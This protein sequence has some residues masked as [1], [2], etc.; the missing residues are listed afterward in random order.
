MIIM[1]L[2]NELKKIVLQCVRELGVA[3]SKQIATKLR[4]LGVSHKN[5]AMTLLNCFRQRLLEREEFKR[6]RV[7]G[8][9]Y[10]LTERGEKRL[11]YYT[12][13]KGKARIGVVDFGELV[14]QA[15]NRVAPLWVSDHLVF[16]CAEDICNTAEQSS[17]FSMGKQCAALSGYS[18]MNKR[19]LISAFAAERLLSLVSPE[20]LA[21]IENALGDDSLEGLTDLMDMYSIRSRFFNLPSEPRSLFDIDFVMTY[22]LLRRM[23]ELHAGQIF[24]Y[25]KLQEEKQKRQEE[26]AEKQMYKQLYED[27]KA[28]RVKEE[29]AR[30]TQGSLLNGLD[31]SFGINRNK[32]RSLAIFYASWVTRLLKIVNT[33]NQVVETF[34]QMQ[35][36]ILNLLKRNRDARNSDT[37][38]IIYYL[39]KYIEKCDELVADN[40]RLHQ[41]AERL[42]ERVHDLQ[43][44]VLSDP[45]IPL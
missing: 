40:G 22:L 4:S 12:M 32:Y 10:I 2:K 8:F 19:E 25:Q 28:R 34:L 23:D 6:G 11:A 17:I 7:R 33:A 16:D 35:A 9:A 44:H 24:L 21:A 37:L 13:Q 15:R 43:D 39:V 29:K 3:T 5:A 38:V 45:S 41:K 42:E 1:F 31:T 36:D 18:I 14:G 20:A 27:E 30:S 26:K